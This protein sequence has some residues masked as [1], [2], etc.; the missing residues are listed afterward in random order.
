MPARPASR[1]SACRSGFTDRPGKPCPD[2]RRSEDR[3]IK[4]RSEYR[5]VYRDPRWSRLREQVLVEEP[6]CACGCG[7]AST[8]V[9]HIRDHGGDPGLAFDRDNCQGMSKPCHDRKT[10]T[11]HR[12]GA[13]S[14]RPVTVVAGPPCAGKTSYVHD[15][16]T[17]GDLVVDYDHLAAALGSPDSHDHPAELKAFASEARAAV[18]A[19]LRRPSEIGRAWVTTTSHTPESLVAGADVVHLQAS[20]EQCHARARAAGR[21]ALWHELIDEWFVVAHTHEG[22]RA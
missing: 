11:E 21:P 15:R 20:L 10:A 7:C 12:S 18:L 16:V 6:L 3:G 2:C 1:C 4:R 22:A 9:D 5:W 17:T 19:R 13:G 8:V 14:P